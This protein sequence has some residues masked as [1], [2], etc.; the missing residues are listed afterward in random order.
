M[1]RKLAAGNWK[2][3]GTRAALAELEKIAAAH[4]EAAVDILICPPYQLLAQAADIA[5]G[6]PV[7]NGVRIPRWAR[8]SLVRNSRATDFVSR[9][10]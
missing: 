5:A 4:P 1:K 2:M 10:S 7:A 8:P 6:S 9:S 3:N